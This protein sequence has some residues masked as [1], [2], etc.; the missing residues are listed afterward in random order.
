MLVLRAWRT[1]VCMTRHVAFKAAAAFILAATLTTVGVLLW[2]WSITALGDYTITNTWPSIW[3]ATVGSALF[4]AGSALAVGT[5]NW[6][7]EKVYRNG[8]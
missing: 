1:V 4:L 6:V 8:R 3:Q 5:Y 2:S 7:E